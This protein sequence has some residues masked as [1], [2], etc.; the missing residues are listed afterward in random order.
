MSTSDEEWVRR[1]RI[2]RTEEEWRACEFLYP[3]TC[4]FKPEQVGGRKPRLFTAACMRRLW[5]WP[6]VEQ[7]RWTVEALERQADGP[8]SAEEAL[9]IASALRELRLRSTEVMGGQFWQLSIDYAEEPETDPWRIAS[10]T[11]QAMLIAAGRLARVSAGL[12]DDR[13]DEEH[14]VAE[15]RAQRDLFRCIFGNPFH[16][17]AF[18]PAWRT[19]TATALTVT[20]VERRALPAGT[21]DPV[22]LAVLA[23]ALEEAGC[24][25]QEL[26]GHLLGRG[27]HVKGCWALD[28]I[29]GCA[30]GVPPPQSIAL[31]SSHRAGMMKPLKGLSGQEEP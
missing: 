25:D 13:P 7:Y 11:A 3:I 26:L 24:P 22:H 10:A 4:L 23:D 1:R 20:A 21:L 28:A 29:L 2:P 17:V 8:M 30:S 18:E 15:E 16:S 9:A 6:Y 14:W 27:P 12:P 31:A 5:H 19:P